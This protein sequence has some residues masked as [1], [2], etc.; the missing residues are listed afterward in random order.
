M[1]CGIILGEEV[2]FPSRNDAF[3]LKPLVATVYTWCEKHL[4]WESMI[5][6]SLCGVG[7][8]NWKQNFWL[9]G[10]RLRTIKVSSSRELLNQRWTS[11]TLLSCVVT[12]RIHV[13]PYNLSI[14][15]I[16]KYASYWRICKTSLPLPS[17][18]Y[19]LG[20]SQQR[21]ERILFVV[22]PLS[23]WSL[24]MPSWCALASS[25]IYSK[26]KICPLYCTKDQ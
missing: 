14:S 13:F 10:T 5:R 7:R 6:C 24:P 16:V 9:K 3:F 21:I 2:A 17:I 26:D 12:R 25:K 4:T 23:P 20:V 15:V 19:V 22:K 11:I 8:S 1:N 18:Q